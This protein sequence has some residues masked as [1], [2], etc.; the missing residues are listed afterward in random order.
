MEADLRT[1]IATLGVCTFLLPVSLSAQ[2]GNAAPPPPTPALTMSQL[3]AA[4]AG[5]WSGQLEYL[6]YGA[7]QWFGIPMT[8]SIESQIDRVTTIRKAD[9]DDGP[10]TGMVR[11]TTVAIMDD[12]GGKESSAIFRKNRPMDADVWQVR[13]AAP[14]RDLTHWTI[15]AETIGRDGNTQAKLRETTTRDGDSLTTL[16]EVD[17]PDD[18]KDEYFARNRTRLTKVGG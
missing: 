3:R 4:T 14:A 1:L 17:P 6:D 16:K 15:I 18:G 5:N 9:F 13:L 2:S 10:V 7:N 11:I 12:T 8:V